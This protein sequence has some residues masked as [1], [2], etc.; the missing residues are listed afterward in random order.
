MGDA[1]HFW[2]STTVWALASKDLLHRLSSLSGTDMA[3]LTVLM[4]E[5]AR[6]VG[7]SESQW[8]VPN[9]RGRLSGNMAEV[10]EHSR[11]GEDKN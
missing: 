8:T 4:V 1:T 2:P 5:A 3:L 10:S 6:E 11:A 7:A 9:I